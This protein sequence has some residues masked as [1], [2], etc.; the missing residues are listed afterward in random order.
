MSKTTYVNG[1]ELEVLDWNEL[2]DRGLI[3]RINREV[4]HP[5]GLAMMRDP[6][7]GQSRGAIVSP[8]GVWQYPEKR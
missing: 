2:S 3:E 1:Q 6:T 8:D 5:L 7:T 4:L